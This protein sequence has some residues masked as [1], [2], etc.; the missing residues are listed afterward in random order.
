MSNSIRNSR[1]SKIQRIRA[2]LF[3]A[4]PSHPQTPT[5]RKEGNMTERIESVR[6]RFIEKGF[7]CL[8]S[9]S[10]GLPTYSDIEAWANGPMLV[11]FVFDRETG[12]WD[13][14]APVDTTN[15]IQATWAAIDNLTPVA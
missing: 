5:S 1:E 11:Y 4:R 12:G 2:A 13:I 3:A 14:L 15:D 8:S 9:G 6:R 10:F 7:H